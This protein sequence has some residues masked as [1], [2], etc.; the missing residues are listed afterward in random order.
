MTENNTPISQPM[1][2]ETKWR[3]TL[4]RFG[5]I[6]TNIKKGLPKSCTF[7]APYKDINGDYSV[8]AN[9]DGTTYYYSVPRGLIFTQAAIKELH[10]QI[11]EKCTTDVPN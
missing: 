9:V 5:N 2:A 6:V 1:Q 8:K 10:S 11:L 7:L 3:M 4:S